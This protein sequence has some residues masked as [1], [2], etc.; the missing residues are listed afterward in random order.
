M[1]AELVAGASQLRLISLDAQRSEQP[2]TGIAGELFQVATR[3][4]GALVICKISYRRPRGNHAKPR[5]ESGEFAQERLEGG[6]TQPSFLWTRR[7][8]ERLQAIQNKQ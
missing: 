5:I 3:R 7:I 2:C 4:G 6:L 1:A 8:L